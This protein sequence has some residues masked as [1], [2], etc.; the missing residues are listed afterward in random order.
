MPWYNDLRPD[1]KDPKKQDY[2]LIFPFMKKEEKMRCIEKLLSLRNGLLN[3]IP[4]RKTDQNLLL[5]S[6]NIKEFGHTSQR[7]SEAF[8]YIAEIISKFDLVAVQ[9]IKSSLNDLNTILRLL[10][11]DW[12]YMVN[13]I[14]EGN[15][16]ND[17]RSAYLYNK[18]T[19]EL[20]G[21]SGEITLWDELTKDSKIKQLK[22]TPFITGFKSGWKKFSLINLHLHP[23]DSE[24]DI[25]FRKEE[26]RLFL[27]AVGEK[28]K[29]KRFWNDN[30]IIL[31]DFNFFKDT[32]RKVKDGPAIQLFNDRKF[33]ELKSL[34]NVD[35]NASLTQVYDRM[36][37]HINQYF[38]IQKDVNGEEK[39]G[40]FNPFNYV[41]TAEDVQAYESA[42]R[43]VYNG[44]MPL[45]KYFDQ[46]WRKNQISDHFPIWTEI[47]ID[48][49]DDF[50][51]SKLREYQNMT[52]T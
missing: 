49:S 20:S 23:G 4:E 12:A 50:L 5:A 44:A 26:V 11:K 27:E 38:R 52:D 21:I 43:K 48:N 31:G 28:L 29:N 9:E 3:E 35:T 30:L 45:D 14:T 37:F 10:G 25:L 42:M 36:F 40:V 33:R 32:S 24:E 13:D 17:E 7:T 47:V 18:K 41:F 19:V 2:A 8:F 46:F 34:A 1:D 22:R 6:W 51:S 39:G 16:G 15:S